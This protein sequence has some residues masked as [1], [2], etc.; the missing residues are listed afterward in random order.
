MSLSGPAVPGAVR[1]GFNR[2]WGIQIV[3]DM[4]HTFPTVNSVSISATVEPPVYADSVIA[5]LSDDLRLTISVS[6]SCA[7]GV[8]F[9]VLASATAPSGVV[10]P[11]QL[12]PV[13][14]GSSLQYPVGPAPWARIVPLR[15]IS[16]NNNSLCVNE[17]QDSTSVIASSTWDP[18][19]IMAAYISEEVHT[20]HA[21]L[22]RDSDAP[23]RCVEVGSGCGIAGLALAA[24]CPHSRVLLTDGDP[25]AC[26]LAAKNVHSNGLSGR[27]EARRLT[28]RSDYSATDLA[29]AYAAI[30]GPP[31][32]V[33]AADVVYR[34][35]TFAA[36]VDTLAALCD[37]GRARSS[38]HGGGCEVLFAYRPRVDDEHFFHL[39]VE[40]FEMTMVVAPSATRA[41]L[42]AATGEE[43]SSRVEGKDNGGDADAYERES[44]PPPLVEDGIAETDAASAACMIYRLRR[45]EV[46]APLTCRVCA[47]RRA[48]AAAAVAAIS[49]ARAGRG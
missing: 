36:L 15:G 30:G 39:L 24:A 13:V 27:V 10:L 5:S 28:W 2:S 35:E 6:R 32:L 25:R 33:L 1:P 43:T 8:T 47:Q 14:V 38:D 41:L 34:E 7:D 21:I 3:S 12:G 40:A 20:Q 37:A 11:L 29:E 31:H 49:S 42:R 48:A 16:G 46:R 22:G 26:A 18:G 4:W 44:S 17:A 9:T 19:V 45:R 23:L